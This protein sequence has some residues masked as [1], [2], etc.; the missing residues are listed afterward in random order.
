MNKL[1]SSQ[2][3]NTFN[4]ILFF[5]VIIFAAI[6][7]VSC[8][9]TH[10]YRIGVSQCSDDD[11]RQK[12]NAEIMREMLFHPEAAIEIR[13]AD[14]SSAKQIADIEYF[15]DNGFDIIIA[16][17][18][19]ADALTPVLSR[20]YDKGIPTLLFDRNIN[21]D[22][23]TA[24]QGADNVDIGHAAG[25]YVENLVGNKAP[26]IE[27]K[28]LMSS[29]PAK[30]R[31]TGFLS[32]DVNVVGS[33]S[34]NWNYDDAERVA[35]SLL[36]L[37]PDAK[38]V[39]AHNDR[40][41]IAAA[42]VARRKGLTP[43]IIGIDAAPEIGMR[44]VADSVIT[45][46]FFYPTA[47][48]QIIQTAFAIL[49]GEPYDTIMAIPASPAVDL[50]NINLL[51]SQNE[52]LKY[53]TTR[54]EE[55]KKEV[56]AYWEQ[57][58]SQ[59]IV[60][61]GVVVIVLLLSGLLFM[62]LR[63]YWQHRRH[64]AELEAATASKLAFFTNVSH[65]LRTPLT[66]IAEPVEQLA[67]ADNL[68]ERQHLLIRLADKNVKLLQRLINQILD[69]RKHEND[70][71]ELNLTEN[72][73]AST[74]AQWGEAFD[75]LARRRDIKYSVSID[76]PADFSMAY[77]VNKTERVFYNL[78]SNAFKYTPDNGTI[79]VDGR[80]DN[81]NLIIKVSDTGQ[82]IS[83][84]DLPM[85]F[86]RFF[87]VD[88]LHPNSSGIGLALV[89]AFV[90]LHDGK[91]DV[92]S[93]KGKGS[94]FT[95]SIP[96]RHISEPVQD[97]APL[98]TATEVDA[99]LSD[100]GTTG[101]KSLSENKVN[102]ETGAELPVV[103]IIDDNPDIRTM[104]TALLGEDYAVIAAAGANEGLRLAAKYTPD[105]IIC[106]VMMPEIDGLECCRRLKADITTSHIPVLMLTACA[107][108]EQR[109]R[110]YEVGAD[111]YISKPFS[112][113]VLLARCH[114]LI[115]NRKRIR[116]VWKDGKMILPDI[117]KPEKGAVADGAPD[118]DN[119]FYRNFI[120]KV[121]AMMGNADLNVDELASEMGLGRSQLYRKI[122][123]LTNYSPIE[124]LRRIR[125]EKARRLLDTTEMTISE[126]AYEVG[127]ATPAYFTKCYRDAYGE[128]PTDTRTARS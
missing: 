94:T 84:G 16:A 21:G 69:F 92:V 65:E 52:L 101:L 90:E 60:F 91:I 103:L 29:T 30:G 5:S 76:I 27:I 44:A 47:G 86:D 40:M 82:G 9:K 67:R 98:I 114:N 95:V 127:F 12:M 85:I 80:I 4:K 38:A 26:V 63:T 54:I 119:D 68:D 33:A 39:Y 96:I 110:G 79:A 32:A 48:E 75:G 70:K 17:P 93:T 74:V 20:A 62:V 105:L 102:T 106:D 7:V 58:S 126:I 88:T 56:D 36:T 22:R 35:D 111:G 25:R 8:E 37:Y 53:E 122:K 43:Y 128:T 107:M 117:P 64:Q 57:H 28:G 34:G 31:H 108:D 116:T 99:E 3:K 10:E 55:L 112:S 124:L 87:Q 66:L 59:T 83:A 11:W 23:F 6:C 115:E 18:N 51:L 46:T 71:L 121:T 45:A 15:I 97:V 72:H 73:V 109:A 13:S 2:F 42:D 19:E 49:N 78:V 1:F 104:L 14:D 24:W 89:K 113:A 100:I 77:D 125:L 50:R 120:D 123:S 81:N 61:Y 41:A 118:I